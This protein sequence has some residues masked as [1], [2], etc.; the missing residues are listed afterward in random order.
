M[1]KA[2]KVP[3]LLQEISSPKYLRKAWGALNKANKNSKGLNN[4]T[5]E[6]FQNALE[7]N[8]LSISKKLKN[9]TYKFN[10]VR[11]VLISKKEKG[12][13]RPLRIADVG[14]RLVCKAI[15]MKL[16]LLLT[17]LFNLNNEASFAY[18]KNK[19]IDDAIRKMIEHYKAGNKIILE[20]DIEKFF[21]KVDRTILLEKVFSNLPDPSLNNLINDGLSQEVGNIN[22]DSLDAHHFDD[23]A[24]GIPQ[25]NALSPLFANV[26]L[27]EFDSKI[28]LAGYKLVRYA[29]DFVILCTTKADS[30]SALELCK[31]ILETDLKLTIHKLGEANDPNSK[32]KII[33]PIYNEFKFLSI[34]FDGKSVWVDRKKV[35]Q[36]REKIREITNTDN[37]PDLISILSKTRNL[38]EG[39]LASFKFVDVD[40]DIEA[41]DSYINDQLCSVFRKFG[42][43]IKTKHLKEI[44]DSKGLVTY[45]FSIEQRKRT[46]IKACASFLNSIDRKKIII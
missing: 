20:A 27:S 5:I 9:N 18:R 15:S 45:T 3:T 44:K 2:K 36:L 22:E 12:K 41:I 35:L 28:L 32:T 16:D 38:L 14:D 21:D 7:T 8:L 19:G 11:G 33:D 4:E 42:F 23:S 6:E 31:Q 1:E 13:F 46:G 24:N 26:Y 30:L 29:D 25:G 10:K 39:W 40:R 17:P 43:N 34:R 37:I